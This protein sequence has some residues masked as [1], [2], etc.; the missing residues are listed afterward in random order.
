MNEPSE[1]KPLCQEAAAS[2]KRFTC[3]FWQQSADALG[4]QEA[5]AEATACCLFSRSLQVYVVLG[6][7]V[8]EFGLF[9]FISGLGFQDFSSVVEV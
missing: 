3:T 5:V 7:Q 9:R 4:P 1:R 8:W 2:S 6:V